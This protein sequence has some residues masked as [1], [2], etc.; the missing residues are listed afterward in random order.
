MGYIFLGSPLVA[1]ASSVCSEAVSWFACRVSRFL[2]CVAE[3]FY[4]ESFL[5]LLFGEPGAVLVYGVSPK[6]GCARA[7]GASMTWSLTLSIFMAALIR[8]AASLIGPTVR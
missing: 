4:A 5:E 1:A 6:S 2:S 7:A 3:Q 8:D